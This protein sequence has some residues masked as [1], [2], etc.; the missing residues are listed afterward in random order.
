MRKKNFWPSNRKERNEE[1]MNLCGKGILSQ[2]P[3]KED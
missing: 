3:E 1:L 2:K